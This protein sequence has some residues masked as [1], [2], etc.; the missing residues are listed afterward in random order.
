MMVFKVTKLNLCVNDFKQ[1]LSRNVDISYLLDHPRS[2]KTS[3]QKHFIACTSSTLTSPN[4]LTEAR[5]FSRFCTLAHLD[6]SGTASI[7]HSP[8][9]KGKYLTVMISTHFL[10]PYLL[11]CVSRHD[12]SLTLG[13][14]LSDGVYT[15]W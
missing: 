12:C 8:S 3:D 7:R 9:E 1:C 11:G 15:L 10:G 6:C 13:I 5:F 14:V 2:F 4:E